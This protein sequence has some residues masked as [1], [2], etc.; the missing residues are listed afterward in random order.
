M[1]PTM[2]PRDNR[3]SIRIAAA[4]LAALLATIAPI[5]LAAQTRTQPAA[6]G[7]GHDH[8][9]DHDHADDSLEKGKHVHGE[10]TFNI[11]LDGQILTIELDAPAINVVGFE[12]AARSEPERNAV[13]AVDTWLSSGREIAAV[14][15]NAGCSLLKADYT[16][17]RLGSGH[18][19][20]RATY[21]FRC[22]NPAA[23]EWVE[24]WAL[25]KLTNVER[26]A[27]NLIT[28]TTQ[29]QQDLA[30]G[31]LRVSLK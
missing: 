26:A 16:P 31:D 4:T 1:L 11:A 6:A 12:K 7:K 2:L 21:S 9:H 13:A 28:A 15:R 27:A 3:F 14:P 18:A 19:D 24:L 22:S 17:P 29:R 23:L 5:S 20:Y 8:D 30:P 25:R 10:V